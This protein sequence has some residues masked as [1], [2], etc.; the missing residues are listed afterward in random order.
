MN[1]WVCL[2]IVISFSAF[3]GCSLFTKKDNEGLQ[4]IQKYQEEM[5]K[6]VDSM[7]QQDYRE[8]MD[9]VN[10]ENNK[11]L[12]ELDSLKRKSDSMDI[13]LDKNMKKLDQRQNQEKPDKKNKSNQ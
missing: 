2:L 11:M 12:K 7:K 9:S 5:N 3:S 8:L 1:I 10:S 6:R 13:E 4:R